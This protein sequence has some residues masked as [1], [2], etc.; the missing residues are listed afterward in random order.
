MNNR[1]ENDKSHSIFRIKVMCYTDMKNN[2]VR[3]AITLSKNIQRN[4]VKTHVNVKMIDTY[5]FFVLKVYM[6]RYS[7]MIISNILYVER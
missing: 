2:L 7:H 6:L 3:T 4:A 5:F 1:I